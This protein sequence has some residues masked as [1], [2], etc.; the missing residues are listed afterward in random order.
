MAVIGLCGVS[1]NLDRFLGFKLGIDL[2]Y[3]E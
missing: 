1:V 3:I 2:L